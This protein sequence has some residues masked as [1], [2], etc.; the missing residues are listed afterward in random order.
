MASEPGS[1]SSELRTQCS[2][3]KTMSFEHSIE[4]HFEISMDCGIWLK[5][6]LMLQIQR[7]KK[8]RKKDLKLLKKRSL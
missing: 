4:D 5:M 8:E 3:E 1:S 7:R 6:A 2:M